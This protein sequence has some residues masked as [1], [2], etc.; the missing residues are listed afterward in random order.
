MEHY[1]CE[2]EMGGEDH[3]RSAE[4]R[5]NKQPNQHLLNVDID[6]R[7]TNKTNPNTHFS[8]YSIK[9]NELNAGGQFQFAFEAQKVGNSKPTSDKVQC[10]FRVDYNL[11]KI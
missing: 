2:I 1:E 4:F 3:V 9:I 11:I 6:V 10:N 8:V 7:V 5:I